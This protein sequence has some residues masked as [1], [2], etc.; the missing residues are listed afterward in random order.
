[1]LSN[2]QL[3]NNI[4]N[5]KYK[6][7]KKIKNPLFYSFSWLFAADS[8]YERLIKNQI[9]N[10]KKNY[11]LI[12]VKKIDLSFYIF[13]N[14]FKFIIVN[15]F[16]KKNNKKLIAKKNIFFSHL[17]NETEL[18]KRSDK[19]FGD[20]PNWIKENF[21]IVLNNNTK[22]NSFNYQ[23]QLK[24]NQIIF[25]DFLNFREEINIFF[26]YIKLINF[27][28]SID[29]SDKDVAKELNYQLYD[30]NIIYNLRK[31]FFI[32]KI[33][34]SCNPKKVF[35]TYEGHHTEA[36]I[37]EYS[38]KFKI[39]TIAYNHSII[40]DFQKL[41]RNLHYYNF[42]PDVILLTGKKIKKKIKFSSNQKILIIGSNKIIKNKSKI[43]N[44]DKKPN[45]CL[46]FG[47][48]EEL[49]KKLFFVIYKF[50]KKNDK[51]KFY[52]KLHPSIKLN[53]VIKKPKI[54]FSQTNIN[55]THEE[56]EKLFKKVKWVIYQRTTAVLNSIYFNVR[57]LY[58]NNHQV[59]IDPLG[60][61]KTWKKNFN[62]EKQLQK[63]LIHDINSKITKKINFLKIKKEHEKYFFSIDKKKLKR[64]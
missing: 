16:Y 58:Y 13:F 17:N 6:L 38:K 31:F 30:K 40:Y 44:F 52:F 41:Y 57:P 64:L 63:I 49:T 25:P 45:N 12:L 15:L 11:Y 9:S 50:A 53:Q 4:I 29:I 46:V 10:K 1:M 26:T 8:N 59:N 60:K 19:Y 48:D 32:K 62:D 3:L 21:Y 2:T 55:L 18:K 35:L 28:K 43:I 51:I 23:E 34:T 20:I 22:K 36:F 7:I 33:L 24:R 47:D 37:I 5:V 54:F 27:F 14:F 61:I 56:N 39:K 42:K